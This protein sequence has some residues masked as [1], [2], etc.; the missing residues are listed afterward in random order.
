MARTQEKGMLVDDQQS[1]QDLDL[2]NNQDLLLKPKGRP[3]VRH[4]DILN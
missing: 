2:V 1:L 4:T 3:I